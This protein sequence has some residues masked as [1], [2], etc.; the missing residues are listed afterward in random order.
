MVRVEDTYS[1]YDEDR[2]KTITIP[3]GFSIHGVDDNRGPTGAETDITR[4]PSTLEDNNTPIV[5]TEV[6]NP[7]EITKDV[8][9]VLEDV[10][11]DGVDIVVATEVINITEISITYEQHINY[12]SNISDEIVTMASV[13]IAVAT[14]DAEVPRRLSVTS[15]PVIPLYNVSYNISPAD[16]DIFTDVMSDVL[17]ETSDDKALDVTDT[18]MEFNNTSVQRDKHTESKDITHDPYRSNTLYQTMSPHTRTKRQI[19]T[20]TVPINTKSTRPRHRRT[21]MPLPVT[22]TPLPHLS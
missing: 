9:Y 8:T 15:L 12:T 19:I 21:T 4:I 3:T 10:T 14:E 17:Y 22:T 7:T 6:L 1:V 11:T 16:R 20:Q 2:V 18:V 5:T 13:D